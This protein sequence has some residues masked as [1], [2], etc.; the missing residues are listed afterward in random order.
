[1][2]GRV[3]IQVQPARNGWQVSCDLPIETIYFRSGAQAESAARRLAMRL[4]GLG[5]DV[6]VEI[7]DRD[8]RLVGTQLYLAPDPV[9]A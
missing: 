6:Q 4:S 9:E 2:I 8:G 1:M 5:H 7:H 3:G